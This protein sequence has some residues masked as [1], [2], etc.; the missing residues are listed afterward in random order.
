M[1]LDGEGREYH[2]VQTGRR[3]S[4]WKGEGDREHVR[5][6]NQLSGDAAGQPIGVDGYRRSFFK[7]EFVGKNPAGVAERTDGERLGDLVMQ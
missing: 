4:L 5:L 7:A 6:V 1:V 3:Q 2:G